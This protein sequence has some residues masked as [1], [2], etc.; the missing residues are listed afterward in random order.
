LRKFETLI[1]RASPLDRDDVDTDQIIPARFL[2]TIGRTGLGVHLFEDWRR[3]PSGNLKSEFVLNKK[4]AGQRQILIAG[5][6]FGCGSSREHAVW[7]LIDFGIVAVIATSFGD[8]FR[9]NSLRN[10]LLPIEASRT[11][12]KA[13]LDAVAHHD[14]EFTVDLE[15]QT[16]TAENVAFDFQIDPFARTCLLE[17]I[18]DLE[19]IL[20]HEK[21]IAAFEAARAPKARARKD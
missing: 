21:E 18:D 5:R 15:N 19:Y 20:K 8:I 11:D 9:K 16:V 2:R 17:G 7:S 4:G 13:C 14:A 6:N 3:D 1:S 10:G 12:Q